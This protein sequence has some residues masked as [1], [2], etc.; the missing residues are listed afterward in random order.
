MGVN[1]KRITLADV[2]KAAGVSTATVDRVLNART[3]VSG[4]RVDLVYEAA[5]RL[6]Y[7]GV[8]ALR[9]R[10]PVKRAV[11]RLGVA[12]RRRHNPFYVAL[13]SAIKLAAGR[14]PD[15]DVDI[16][17]VYQSNNSPLEAASLI[18]DLAQTCQAVAL[19]APDHRTVSE[20]VLSARQRNVL[21]FSLLSDF[22][23]DA[24]QAYLG[25]DNRKA[26]RTAA[27]GVAHTAPNPGILGI[28]V[29]NYS[30]LAQEMREAG[31]RSYIRE[32]QP[33]FSVVDTVATAESEDDVRYAVERLLEKHS[34]LVGI[35]VASGG[36]EGALEAL[37]RKGRTGKVAVVC[38]ET[39]PASREAL[40]DRSAMMIIATPVEQLAQQLVAEAVLAIN[41]SGDEL[42]KPGP[43]PFERYVSENI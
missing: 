12:L 20:A 1:S 22:A 24:R 21:T 10:L 43:I 32:Q 28:V 31:F 3:P 16:K 8:R 25:L 13:E 11:V 4:K 42:S 17:L 37:R 14:Y 19:M 6:N 15:T 39:T 33:D 40:I 27:W 41:H 9:S 2:A 34:D 36:F 29:G 7:H 30:Y 38:N 35:Y 23:I 5:R 26:G 18:E